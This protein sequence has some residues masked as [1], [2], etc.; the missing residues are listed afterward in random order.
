MKRYF[1]LMLHYRDERYAMYQIRRR[2]SW[3]AKRLPPSKRW[4]EAV[5]TAPDAAAVYD[6]IARFREIAQRREQEVEESCTVDT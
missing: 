6:A 1:D 4:R 3:F 5:R 2:V